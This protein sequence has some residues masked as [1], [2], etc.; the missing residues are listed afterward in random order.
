MNYTEQEAAAQNFKVLAGLRHLFQLF[1]EHGAVIG[2]DSA[3]IVVDLNKAP[4]IMLNEIGEI[5]RTSQLVAPNGAMGIFD[6]FN[7]GD[8]TG[9]LLMN[10]G[11][12]L[13]NKDPIF[14]K[15][16]VFVLAPNKVSS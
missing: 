2:R 1:S 13:A 10:I 8:K 5:Y 4:S 9:V 15:F 7:T 6:N 12:P 3:R 14:S 16:P 11:R